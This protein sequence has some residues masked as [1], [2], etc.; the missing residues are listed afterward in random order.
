MKKTFAFLHKLLPFVDLLQNIN[1][2]VS[3]ELYFIE[4]YKFYKIQI[5]LD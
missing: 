2:Q 5:A 1:V 4:T 3:E